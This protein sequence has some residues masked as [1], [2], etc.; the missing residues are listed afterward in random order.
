MTDSAVIVGAGVIGLAT[1][2]RLALDGLAVTVVDAAPGGTAGASEHNAGWIVPI[3]STPVP[4]PGMLGQALRWMARRDSPLYVRP[5]PRPEHVRFMINMLRHC[6]PRDFASGVEALTSLNERTLQLFD[7]YDKDGVRFE[8]HRVGQLLVFTTRHTMEEYRSASAPMERISHT[9][10]PLS[11]DELR[12]LEP[13]L[14]RRVLTGLRCPQ[15]RHVDPAS[16]VRGLEERCREL[17]VRFLHGSPVTGVR[18]NGRSVT[19]VLAAGEEVPGDL[20][21]LAAGV[22]TGPLA[23]L[24]GHALPIRPGKGYGFDD[25]SGSV[26][27]RHSVYLGE[28][29][30]AVTPLSD[31][32]RFAGTMEFGSSDAAID[33]HRLRGIAR[34]AHA[35]LPDF[36]AAAQPQGW[37]GLRP[38][39]PDGLP[40]IGPLPGKD[41]V[42]VASG[43]SMLGVTLAPVTADIIAAEVAGGRRRADSAGT[44]LPFSPRRFGVRRARSTADNRR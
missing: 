19:S 32:L 42:L 31:R 37:T 10:I 43:H 12:D 36:P 3:M 24:A 44:A 29:K 22:R 34:S 26:T 1:A 30:V 9:A 40:V 6:N 8:H 39:T 11:G 18:S 38:M 25:T 41:N 15:E 16:L 13:A 23:R 14:I 2:Y 20:F 27:L 21:V 33:P 4:A 17:G 5:S 28:A 7:E 35:Y